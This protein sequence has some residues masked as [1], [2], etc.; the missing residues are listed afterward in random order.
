MEGSMQ[1]GIHYMDHI[2]KHMELT[3]TISFKGPSSS[4]VQTLIGQNGACYEHYYSAKSE[5]GDH[6]GIYNI[7]RYS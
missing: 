7:W 6:S 4:G 2:L 5:L 3:P 1:H